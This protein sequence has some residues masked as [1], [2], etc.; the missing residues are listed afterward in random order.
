MP[1]FRETTLKSTPSVPRKERIKDPKNTMRSV[2]PAALYMLEKAKDQNLISSYDRF[3]AQ[4]PQCAFGYEGICCRICFQGP[5][6]I[7]P[8]D[9]PGSKGIC[10]A[11]AYTIVARNIA[12]MMAGGCSA[13]SDHGRH[14]V[15]ALLHAAEGKLAD[16]KVTD[17]EKLK[18]IA[19]RI[20][21]SAEGKTDNEL[22]V[23]V[24]KA[25]LEDFGR[26]T[27]ETCTWLRTTITEGRNKK[28]TDCNIAP[29]AIDRAV[30]SLLHQ[31]HI[32]TDAD[33][34]NIIFG[35]L[36]CGLAD[37]TGM[38]ISTDL[39]DVLFGTPKPVVSEA[40]LGV[41]KSDKV[42][43]ILHGHNPILSQTVVNVA[44]E[45]EAEAKAAGAT[46]IQLSG[47]CC[48]GNE[49]LMRSGVP[50]ATNF[51]SQ[52]LAIMTGAVDVMVVDVQCIMPSVQSVA[53][54]FQTK[55]VTT[56]DISKIPGAHHFAFDEEHA[57][58]SAKAVIRLAIE[59]FKNRQ[60]KECDIP[61]IKNKV[62]AGFSL[63]AL[64]ELFAAINPEAP[65]KVLTDAIE[66]GELAGVALLCGCNNL[67]SVHDNNHL[68][69]ARELAKNNVFLVG[70]GCSAQALAKAGMLAPEAI[71]EYAG[72]GLKNF[73]KRLADAN[74][75][76]L[77]DGL[78]L[79]FHMGSCVDNSRAHDL[80]TMMAKQ[81]N[82]DTP[83]VPFVA[84]APEAM[85]EKAVSI[86]AGAVAMGYPTHVGTMPPIEGSPLVFGIATQIA[87]DVYGGYFIFETDPMVAAAKLLA[88]L[89]NRTWKLGIHK[90]TA[91]K[92]ET[93]LCENY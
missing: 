83:K 61:Q 80:S 77:T 25:A 1:R 2:D 41:L 73:L 85:S 90:K 52:E 88:S 11:T 68:T 4:Q 26:Q 82:V 49:V 58:D 66:S 89:D 60:G 48:T 34:V 76:K 9:G 93:K 14:I 43:V 75:D 6:R 79:V 70:T 33:P 92:F 23:E 47:I 81:L 38:H 32:G 64:V 63:E 16:F 10:G 67:E 15:H 87:S 46:G 69:I 8:G 40:N 84:S 31:T 37:Y 62:I 30:V 12:R 91:E 53:E 21:I 39:S 35:G 55:I 45:M 44:Q 22:A 7:K 3:A 86:G 13:H 27:D 72:E 78:P 5:C 50:I 42:N 18:S 28:F 65:I 59:A 17:V 56:M 51:S 57:V 29:T 24:A 36:K 20:D 74:Q 19:E 71:D 54:C